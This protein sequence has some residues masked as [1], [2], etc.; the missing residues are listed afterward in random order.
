MGVDPAVWRSYLLA[1]VFHIPPGG[2]DDL[3]GAFLD[4][5]LAVHQVVSEVQ[6]RAQ[7]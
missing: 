7:R 3:P 1:T 4:E 5:M 2:D 6:A